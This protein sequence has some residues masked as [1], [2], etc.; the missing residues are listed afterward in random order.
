M[1]RIL[2]ITLW[3]LVAALSPGLSLAADSNEVLL[4]V[5]GLISKTNSADKK[6]YEFRFDDLQKLGN[7]DIQATNIYNGKAIYTG[8]LIR[9]VL[10]AAGAKQ[11]AKSVVFVGLDDYSV[12]VPIS[13]L[14]KWDVI[15][16]HSVNG[17][18]MVIE[19]KGPLW[20][21]YPLDQDPVNLANTNTS[22]KLVWNLLKIIVK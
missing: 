6:S 14:D 9:D 12:R 4:N 1:K 8:P 21:M 3:L 18:R 20:V 17:K 11:N 22:A 15:I 7:K 10:K 13:D 2:K 5:S 16:A 19:T